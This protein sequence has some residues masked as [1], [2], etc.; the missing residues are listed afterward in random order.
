MITAIDVNYKDDG[1]AV[2]GA[3]VFSDYSDSTAYRT[4]LSEILVVEEYKAGQ[5]Y[6][7]ELP[8][9]MAILR[10]IEEKIHTVIIDG[11]VDIGERPGLGRHL[12]KVLDFKKE[13]IGVAKKY[14]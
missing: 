6:R 8:C 13:V 3:V 2:V 9:I 11:Y 12:W 1:S 7:R 14:F 10:I 5:F 4:Y